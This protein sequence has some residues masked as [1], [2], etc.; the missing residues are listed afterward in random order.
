MSQRRAHHP[1]G[2]EIP[3]ATVGGHLAKG[4][5]LVEVWCNDC[6]RCVEVSVNHLPPDLPIPDIALH[7]RC[8]TCGCRNTSSRM[9]ISEFYRSGTGR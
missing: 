2:T 8:S 5:H 9:S 1:D 7:F 6:T 3:P 4:L